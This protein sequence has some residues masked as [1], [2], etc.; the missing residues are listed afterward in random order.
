MLDAL[1]IK[2]L[3]A[4]DMVAEYS[5]CLD[6][7]QSVLLQEWHEEYPNIGSQLLEFVLV[8]VSLLLFLFMILTLRAD[9]DPGA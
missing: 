6:V 5:G 1:L 3:C 4:F 9:T 7:F 2:W 8:K